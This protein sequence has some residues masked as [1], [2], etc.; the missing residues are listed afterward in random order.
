MCGTSWNSQTDENENITKR[1]NAHARR[2]YVLKG[3]KMF[4]NLF[5]NK[6]NTSNNIR[7]RNKKVITRSIVVEKQKKKFETTTLCNSSR[8][9]S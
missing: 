3:R 9:T 6:T 7:R 1:I 5:R 2:D 4:K 8:Q